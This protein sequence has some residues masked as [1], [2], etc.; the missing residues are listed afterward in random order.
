MKWKD[1]KFVFQNV[2]RYLFKVSGLFEGVTV[3]FRLDIRQTNSQIVLV[4][5]PAVPSFDH[6]TPNHTEYLSL[7]PN[8]VKPCKGILRK[9]HC[10]PPS[11]TVEYSRESVRTSPCP[12]CDCSYL[13]CWTDSRNAVTRGAQRS[14]AGGSHLSRYPVSHHSRVKNKLVPKHCIKF[15]F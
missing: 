10:K 8:T 15:I 12:H 2:E 7:G 11:G 1:L 14:L 13:D 3:T 5:S 9:N 6:L 4:F